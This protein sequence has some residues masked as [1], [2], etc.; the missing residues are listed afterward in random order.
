MRHLGRILLVIQFDLILARLAAVR[1]RV[2]I[3]RAVP[4]RRMPRAVVT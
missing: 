2:G 3:S 4:F 1:E